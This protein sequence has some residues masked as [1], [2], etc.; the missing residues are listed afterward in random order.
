MAGGP[1]RPWRDFVV[2]N[3]GS[4]R[5]DNDRSRRVFRGPVV[6]FANPRDGYI[7]PQTSFCS[8]VECFHVYCRSVWTPFVLLRGAGF[9]AHRSFV[10]VCN[11]YCVLS[12]SCFRFDDVS[13]CCCCCCVLSEICE[14][15]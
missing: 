14:L 13:L 9:I 4:G 7:Y 1:Y 15:Y 5:F 6:W 2:Q 3:R 11:F 12:F 10:V 8:S